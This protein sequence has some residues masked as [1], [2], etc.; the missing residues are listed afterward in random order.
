MKKAFMWVAIIGVGYMVISAVGKSNADKRIARAE[1]CLDEAL[2]PIK[3]LIENAAA[4]D[5]RAE[6]RREAFAVLE[7]ALQG[8]SIKQQVYLR[9]VYTAKINAM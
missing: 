8:L 3:I 2:E 1:E 5:V 7:Q 9:A 6:I 4:D